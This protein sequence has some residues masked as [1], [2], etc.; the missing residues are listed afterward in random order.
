M[1]VIGHEGLRLEVAVRRSGI[2]G[3]GLFARERFPSR[4]KLGE[5]VGEIISEREGRKRAR[6]RNRI[7]I[8]ELGNGRAV[9]AGTN[10]NA[11]RF[12]NHSCS[13]N[14][15]IRIFRGHV[16]FYALR[17]IRPGEELTCNYGDSH[18]DGKLPCRCGADLCRGFI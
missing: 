18:H 3:H 5:M 9:D 7:A 14:S 11:F 12:V 13:P 6:E 2:E 10:G 17:D 8:V 15:F 16:E 4:R 1:S